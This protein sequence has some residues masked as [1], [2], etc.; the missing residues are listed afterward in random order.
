MLQEEFLSRIVQYLDMDVLSLDRRRITSEVEAETEDEKKFLSCISDFVWLTHLPLRHDDKFHTVFEQVLLNEYHCELEYLTCHV[1]N[2]LFLAMANEFLWTA[3]HKRQFA[4]NA[5]GAYYKLL[6]HTP[7][8]GSNYTHIISAICRIYQY[9]RITEFNEDEFWQRCVDIAS[10]IQDANGFCSL[11]ISLGLLACK[12]K[13]EGTVRF[14]LSLIEHY[15]DIGDYGKSIG[16]LDDLIKHLR[17]VKKPFKPLYADIARDYEQQ[18]RCMEWN[19]PQNA[20]RIVDLIHKAMSAWSRSD[21]ADIK[22]N[23]ERLAREIIP[24][25]ALIPTTMQGIKSDSI[26]MSESIERFRD[27]VSKDSFEMVIVHIVDSINLKRFSDFQGHDRD[28]SFSMYGTTTVD[29]AGRALYHTPAH[30]GTSHE[31]M[32]KIAFRDAHKDYCVS[33]ATRLRYTLHFAAEKFSFTPENL[34]FIVEE[35]AFV[36]KDRIDS[37]L[38]GLTAGFSGDWVTAMHILMPQVEN[39]VRCL[40]ENCDL[41][42]YKTKEDGTE[43]CMS[44]SGIL[45][46]PEL[47]EY[48]DEDFLFNLKVFY[49]SEFGFGMRDRVAHGLLSDNEMCSL[50]SMAVWCF[51]LRLCCLY[52]KKFFEWWCREAKDKS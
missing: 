38:K 46:M 36:P 4:E 35:N 3:E 32:E 21:S 41:I 8:E 42:V 22:T 33:A 16:C 37:F 39:A 47:A 31:D 24:V 1:G 26:D 30:F 48:L 28:F 34:R 5:I 29:K 20:V 52:S 51:T 2:Q 25:K 44:L 50:E 9:C 6:C 18:A 19:D 13:E 10:Q 43:E 11:F 23:R 7:S 49:T 12:I 45:D 17:T 15:R 40:A 14:L 27:I